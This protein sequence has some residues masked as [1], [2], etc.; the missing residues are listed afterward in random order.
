MQGVVMR[1]GL[2]FE[3]TTRDGRLIDSTHR[4]YPFR[5]HFLIRI[6]NFLCPIYALYAAPIWYRCARSMVIVMEEEY[7][8]KNKIVL[9]SLGYEP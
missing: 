2:K 7:L 1:G 3:S 8:E 6:L 5:C 4:E 9:V